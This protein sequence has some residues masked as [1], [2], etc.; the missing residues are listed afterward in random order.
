MS[1]TGTHFHPAVHISIPHWLQ[2][3][4]YLNDKYSLDGR[5]PSGYVGVMWSMVGIHDMVSDMYSIPSIMLSIHLRISRVYAS[6]LSEI[7]SRPRVPISL[8]F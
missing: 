4:I 1:V 6:G 5:D 3:A 7:P 2:I 8:A